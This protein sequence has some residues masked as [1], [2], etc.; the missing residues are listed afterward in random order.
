M[1]VKSLSHAQL[2]ATPWTADHQA[3]PPMGFSRQEYWSGMPLPSPRNLGH[4]LNKGVSV[5]DVD[6]A[7]L[8]AISSEKKKEKKTATRCKLYV[9]FDL[10]EIRMCFGIYIRI[11]F[12]G[13]DNVKKNPQVLEEDTHATQF[14]FSAWYGQGRSPGFVV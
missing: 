12:W 11:K 2:V 6:I 10:F 7:I 14:C 9:D 13:I 1:K 5:C 3:P 8:K 4:F